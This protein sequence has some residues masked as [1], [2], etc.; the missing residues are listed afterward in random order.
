MN[1]KS[2]KNL[3]TI[4]FCLI[5]VIA[6]LWIYVYA[7]FFFPGSYMLFYGTNPTKILWFLRIVLPLLYF[8]FVILI[9]NLRLRT[10]TVKEIMIVLAV[11]SLSVYICYPIADSLYQQWFDNHR[12]AYHPYLQLMPN[13]DERLNNKA[14]NIITVFCVGGSTTEFPDSKG[15]DW[16]SR[17]ETILRT[18]YGFPNVEVHNLGRQWYTSLHTLINYETNLRRHKP[19]IVLIMQSVNDLLQNAD[20]SYFSRGVFRYDYGHFYGPV[21]RIIDRRSLWRYLRDVVSGLWY[22]SPRKI[23]TTNHFPG[24]ESYI[25]NITTIIELAKLDSTKVVLMTEPYLVKKDMSQL[26]LSVIGMSKVEAIND[27]MVWSN[28]TILNGID[29]P[30]NDVPMIS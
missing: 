8:G 10:I 25:R 15:R 17:V 5:I 13:N 4:D 29:L 22:A 30:P 19:S 9:I 27:T 20:F 3:T 16:P 7:G 18:T 1:L 21:N 23:V 14:P 28:E 11:S 6:I 2:I 12:Q 24:L 26:E